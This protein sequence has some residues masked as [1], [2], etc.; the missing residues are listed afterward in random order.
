MFLDVWDVRLEIS[1]VSSHVNFNGLS[2]HMKNRKMEKRSVHRFLLTH[3]NKS[4]GKM[5]G[6]KNS[7]TLTDDEIFPLSFNTQYF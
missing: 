1:A 4:M 5:C 3:L 7:K 2:V 6:R